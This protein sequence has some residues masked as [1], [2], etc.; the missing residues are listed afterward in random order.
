[1]NIFL[2]LLQRELRFQD[3]FELD[4]N[5]LVLWLS[6]PTL[7][8]AGKSA[9]LVSPCISPR[10]IKLKTIKNHHNKFLAQR[11]QRLSENSSICFEL[12]ICYLHV[13]III[14]QCTII[15][16][17]TFSVYMI[18]CMKI[19]NGFCLI[20]SLWDIITLS[21]PLHLSQTLYSHY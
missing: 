2:K 12:D 7:K 14:L 20:G 6:I 13:Y 11:Q 15:T 8:V 21:P 1:M 3:V 5:H 17:T 4:M 19:I 9:V 16:V 10:F 18:V